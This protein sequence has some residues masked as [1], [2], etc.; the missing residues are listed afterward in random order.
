MDIF[1]KLNTLKSIEPSE[2][3][4]VDS[5]KKVL[6]EAPI[7]ERKSVL[8]NNILKVDSRL[9]GNDKEGF[10][11]QDLFQNLTFKKLMVPAF[12]LV[13]VLSTGV[14]TLGASKSSLP[15]E[16]LYSIKMMNEDMALVVASENKKAEIEMEHAGKRLEE[17]AVISKKTSDVEQ[18]EKIA[19]LMERFEEKVE[20]AND[21][22]TKIDKSGEKTKIAKVINTQSEKYTEA[23]A[24]TTDDLPAVVKDEILEEVAKAIDSSEKIN[25]T[26]LAA[27]VEGMTDEDKEEI[28]A[29]VKEKVE[30]KEVGEENI[31]E[32][33]EVEESSD[34]S[35]ENDNAD[36]DVTETD[37]ADN[38]EDNTEEVTT[39]ERREEL[40][41]DLDDLSGNDD[42]DVLGDEN[43]ICE[44]EAVDECGCEEVIEE[45][46]EEEAMKEVDEEADGNL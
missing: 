1:S 4:V 36:Q 18:Q 28:T 31:T 42:G 19:Q 8:D 21:S 5:K 32:D 46:T 41:K 7:F 23:L 26:S 12:S 34:E 39:D 22:L 27:M 10:N 33:E 40:L 30:E 16:L 29:M 11:I 15:G 14:F 3:W 20:S 45:K 6:S 43:C 44:I 37:D 2:S 17:M 38:P 9:R 13:F 25:L 24:K 35:D